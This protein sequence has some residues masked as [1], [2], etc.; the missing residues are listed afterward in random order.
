MATGSTGEVVDMLKDQIEELKKE[1]RH[2]ELKHQKE[3][4]DFQK[5]IMELEIHLATLR[6]RYKENT[7]H[8]RG[9]KK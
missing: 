9:K 7:L 6:E 3:K 5:R 8:S 4:E 1:M 2:K